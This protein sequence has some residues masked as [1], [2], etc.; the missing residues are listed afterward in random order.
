[1]SECSTARS[2]NWTTQRN[3]AHS[4]FPAQGDFLSLIP[5]QPGVYKYFD[6]SKQIIYVGKAKNL[7]NRMASY[8]VARE[9]LSPK[10]RILVSKIAYLDFIVVNNEREA[11]LLEN[12]LIKENKP[13]YNIL[14]KDDKTYPWICITKDLYPRIIITRRYNRKYGEFFGPY[15]SAKSI[16]LTLRQI[17]KV[18]PYR[19]CKFDISHESIAEGKHRVCLEYH[20][21][22]CRGC[23]EGR[24]SQAEY[25]K[26]IDNI[27][28]ILKGEGGSILAQMEKEVE[29]LSGNLEFEKAALI[30]ERIEKLREY[31]SKQVVANP[32]VGNLD[33]LTIIDWKDHVVTNYMQVRKGY[34]TMSTNREIRN[35]LDEEGQE[36][37]EHS[38]YTM[39]QM[40]ESHETEIITNIPV[41][42]NLSEHLHVELPIRGD[43]KKLVELSVMNCRVYIQ[44]LRKPFVKDEQAT[45]EKLQTILK[46]PTIPHRIECIDN[47]NLLG[48]DAV[49]SVVVFVDG[50]PKKSDYRIYN[51]KTV[52]GPNDYKTMVEVITR[53]YG[54]MEAQDYPDLILLDG[55]K[56]QLKMGIETLQNLGLAGKLQLAALA[57]RLE[58]IY[59]L[60]DPYPI[61]LDK[62]SDELKMLQYLRDEA[63]RFGI[64]SHRKKRLKHMQGS[65]LNEV[66]GIGKKSV[67]AIYKEYESL[68]Q[69]RE[70]GL[71]RLVQCL[72]PAKAQLVWEAL[73]GLLAKKSGTQTNTGTSSD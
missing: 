4:M 2:N 73:D 42:E 31:E 21:H 24:E 63:H 3:L 58:E 41:N 1:M 27:R 59:L 50:K 44:D 18:A 53:R 68:E 38:L 72:G 30:Q 52:E 5:Q 6:S 22:N 35:P 70:Q 46:L 37:F 55:G 16:T 43:K 10:T 56:G 39:Q 57:E 40:Y 45:L 25:L 8:F 12:S 19:T 15:T 9:N 23:C 17:R 13:K 7:K 34:I 71:K 33:I 51:V 66:A 69:I 20:I 54:K 67:E 32:R 48:Q 11:F 14:L 62:R 49:S 36:I 61:A 64:T 65:L 29:A 47:S 60:G 26:S 28:Q